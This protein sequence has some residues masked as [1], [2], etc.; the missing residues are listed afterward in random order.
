MR[1]TEIAE[2]TFFPGPIR[3]YEMSAATIALSHAAPPSPI[4]PSVIQRAHLAGSAA[5]RA[6]GERSA[7]WRAVAVELPG[8]IDRPALRRALT[9]FVRRHDTLRSGFRGPGHAR[10]LLMPGQVE[11][12]EINHGGTDVPATGA[13]R[14]S[15]I[16][17]AGTDPSVWPPY[18]F[19]TVATTLVLAFDH[20]DMDLVSLA[21]AADEIPALYHDPFATLPIAPSYLDHCRRE[22]AWLDDYPDRVRAAAQLWRETALSP[23][24]ALPAFYADLGTRP[25]DRV[26]LRFRSVTLLDDRATGDLQN[27][28]LRA[29]APLVAGLLAAAAL[30]AHRLTGT[31]GYRTILATQTRPAGQAR[32]FGWYVNALPI[33]IG[34]LDGASFGDALAGAA[35]A[36]RRGHSARRA[37][38]EQIWKAIDPAPTGNG[39]W[40]SFADL[41]ETSRESARMLVNKSFGNDGD[42]WME[43]TGSGLDICFRYP[44]NAVADIAITT[45]IST[46]SDILSRAVQLIP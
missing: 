19:A 37:P 23:D 16:F 30:T 34:D 8:P 32:A 1:K 6:R 46:L 3:T 36:L 28:C 39:S 14:L 35:A 24:H 10:F 29:G 11:L 43:R 41:R 17:D 33:H 40:F 22:Q 12:T 45:W 38:Y 7:R 26:P 5:R 21:V 20:L 25:G 18:R 15:E 2:F 9:E 13:A 31:V 44:D 27:R 4:P 42:I